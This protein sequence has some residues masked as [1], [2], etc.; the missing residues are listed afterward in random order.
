VTIFLAVIIAPFL[1]FI[2][3]LIQGARGVQGPMDFDPV[4]MAFIVAGMILAVVILIT[5]IIL[6]VILWQRLRR[7]APGRCVNCGYDLRGNLNSYSCPECGARQ[8]FGKA[9]NWG[10]DWVVRERDE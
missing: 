8:T 5:G 3:M 10:R 9:G 2:G 7:V 1:G 4:V 6:T